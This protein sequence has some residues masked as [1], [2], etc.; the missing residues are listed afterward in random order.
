MHTQRFSTLLLATALLI[1]LI[2]APHAHA[3]I[4][5]FQI[6]FDDG[7]ISGRVIA[8]DTGLPLEGVL[9]SARSYYSGG[10]GTYY[11]NTQTD[12]TY[13]FSALRPDQY[14]VQFTPAGVA[15]P[16]L[17]EWYDNQ[18]I[19]E[20]GTLLTVQNGST[21]TNINAALSRGATISGV[22]STMGGNA[23]LAIY[24]S[25]FNMSGAALRTAI[26]DNATGAYQFGGLTSGSYTIEF[27][28]PGYI[29]EF[30][31]D[32]P[33]ASLANLIVVTAPLTI[34]NI[35]A[36]LQAGGSITGV[37]TAADTGL[38]ITAVSVNAYGPHGS[39]STQTDGFGMYE[40]AGLPSGNYRLSFEHG[41]Y[42][43]PQYLPESYNNRPLDPQSPNVIAV[44]APN[45]ITGINAALDPAGQI[46]GFVAAGD[47]SLPLGN[48]YVSTSR[49]CQAPATTVTSPDGAFYL[50]GLRAGTFVLELSPYAMMSPYAMTSVSANVTMPPAAPI[51]VTLQRGGA[52][53]GAVL[54][55]GA[56]PVQGAFVVAHDGTYGGSAGTGADG[57]FEII[58]LPSS[59]YAISVFIGSASPDY[60]TARNAATA[61]VTAPNATLAGNITLSIGSSISGRVTAQ[62][63]GAPLQNIP[64]VLYRPDGSLALTGTGGATGADGTYVI[65]GVAPGNYRI[66]FNTPQAS[67]Y[68][69][70]GSEYVPE[71]FNNQ[72]ISTTATLVSVPSSPTALTGFDATLDRGGRISGKIVDVYGIAQPSVRVSVYDMSDTFLLAVRSGGDG[73]YV[74]GPGLPTGQYKVRFDYVT[75]TGQPFATIFYRNVGMSIQR[76]DSPQGSG[77]TLADAT[78][79]N[80]VQ[81]QTTSSINATLITGAAAVAGRVTNNDVGVGGFRLALN[82]GDEATTDA[83]GYYTFTALY[84]GTFTIAPSVGMSAT[85]PALRAVAVPPNGNA[86]DFIINIASATYMVSGR[87]T[88]GGAGLSGFKLNVSNGAQVVTDANGNY[89]LANLPAGSYTI[90]PAPGQAQTTPA[91]RTV[92]LPPDASGLNFIAGARVNLPT[93]LKK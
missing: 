49:P 74:T 37:V 55:V 12:G 63:T 40:L 13:S 90:A 78:P 69:P 57:R 46:Q 80:V 42:Y 84:T 23:P 54:G 31:N 92:T 87:V 51:T 26:A 35:N 15:S 3:G 45:V 1:C 83:N 91:S 79:V 25:L 86:Q 85:T 75:C 34:A 73:T 4:H 39:Y 58:G 62:D 5:T 77:A 18:G 28:A 24:A 44:T 67:Y 8:E 56:A 71:Y 27:S 32:Q 9:V 16:Y 30:Y 61:T 60:V 72:A 6:D 43:D 22:I 70:D 38:G 68:N 47:T 33:N 48:I 76:A 10:S 20:A 66:G 11:T 93:V 59:T 2:N 52:I 88:R 81:D 89:S 7:G 50:R 14:R 53:S 82:N 65:R 64:V 29:S 41:S 17:G 19:E 21:V 36:T